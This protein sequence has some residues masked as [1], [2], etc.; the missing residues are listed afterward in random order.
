[1]KSNAVT[2]LAACSSRPGRLDVFVGDDE[3]GVWH[4]TFDGAWSPWQ[5]LG[6]PWPSAAGPPLGADWLTVTSSGPGRMEL[7]AVAGGRELRHRHF[8]EDCW[9]E[10]TSHGPLARSSASYGCTA[11]A[12]GADDVHVFFHDGDS[13]ILHWRLNGDDAPLSPGLRASG[14]VR[15]VAGGDEGFD[16][17]VSDVRRRRFLRRRFAYGWSDDWDEL[18]GRPGEPGDPQPADSRPGNSPSPAFAATGRDLFTVGGRG[19]WHNAWTRQ[20]GW[21]DLGGDLT[22]GGETPTRLAAVSSGDGRTD[23]IAV[24]AGVALMHRWYAYGREWSD[25]RLIDVWAAPQERRLVRPADLAALR[26][27][28][29]GLRERVR[30]DGVVE[31]L[32]ESTGARLVVELPPQHVTETVLTTGTSSQARIAGPTRLHFA[33]DQEPVPLTVE[34]VLTAMT[35]LPLVVTPDATGLAGTRLELPSRLLLALPQDAGCAHRTL[36][37]DSGE[38]TTELWHSRITG[39]HGAK[40]LKV[41]PHKALPVEAGLDT[42]LGAHVASIAALGAQYPE[43]Q[44]DVDRLILSAYGAWFSA[45]ATWPTLEWTHDASMG[46]DFYVRVLKRGALFPFGHRAAYVETTERRFDPADSVAALRRKRVLIVTEPAR[47]YGIGEGGTHE[48]AFPFQHVAIEPRQLTDLDEPHWLP[49]KAF[50]PEQG[51][52]TVEFTVHARADREVVELRLPLLF[53]DDA[54]TGTSAAAALD[55]DYA[56]GPRSGIRADAGRPA[57]DVGRRIALAM[58][59]PTQALDGAVQE[60]RSMAF[61]AVGAAAA[62]NGVGFHP[63]VTRLQVALP[64][65][66][67]LLGSTPT[68]PAEFTKAFLATGPGAQP[69]ETMLKLLE[70]KALDFGAAGARTGM[71][72]APNMTVT[73]ISRKMG[74]VVGGPFPPRPQDMFDEDAK[75]F[76]VVPL[77]RI[78]SVITTRPEI[79]WSQLAD[80]A[81][82]KLTWKEKLSSV[83]EPFHPGAASWVFLEVVS[84]AAGNTPTLRTTGEITDFTLEIPQRS[85]A[86]VIL[87]FRKVTFTAHSGERPSLTFDLAD[88]ELAGKLNFVRTLADKIPKTGSGGPRIDVSALRIKASYVIA[89]PTVGMGVFTVQ[90]LALEIGL[91]LSLENRPVVIDFAFATREKP[92]LVTVSGFG[93]GGYLELGIS[94]GGSDGGLQRFVGGIEFGASVAMNFGVA[95]GEVHVF[96]GVVFV[97]QGGSIEITGYLRIGGSVSVLGLIRVSVELTISLTYDPGTNVLHGS[98]KLVITVDLTFWST[99]VTLECHKSFKGPSLG[100]AEQRSLSAEAERLRASSVETALGPQ[101]ESFPWQT[102]CQAFARE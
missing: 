100:F 79:T 65:V 2:A 30:A 70:K 37:L 12:T 27:R 28:G 88:A 42:P 64:A 77:R 16:L 66:R 99:S 53:V 82:A 51:G 45:T 19:L 41:R 7:F 76:G 90:N 11:T 5:A 81:S 18:A 97:K 47:S 13:E 73:E 52:T 69:P 17:L 3:G 20:P 9:G 54:A 24:W 32:A 68:V 15:A 83:V 63:Q 71:L 91:T 14:P 60:V 89:V 35:R 98:A 31:V 94:A 29:I 26:V 102:Y 46:R 38:G 4:G 10:W 34:G 55:A 85:S 95:S 36:P 49:S 74:P 59:S 44:V 33:V 92:F 78:I 87:T 25:W 96:G 48:R 62:A 39:P 43:K 61:G 80:V 101:G 56:R 84:T 72:A 67:Q 50:W 40:A 58:Q 75:I 21:T 86:L 1:M 23:V 22:P 6:S 93:G 57:A 8:A